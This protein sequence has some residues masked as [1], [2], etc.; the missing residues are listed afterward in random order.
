MNIYIYI[1]LIDIHKYDLKQSN[2]KAKNIK[3]VFNRLS[4][5]PSSFCLHSANKF[6]DSTRKVVLSRVDASVAPTPQVDAVDRQD[7]CKA[8]GQFAKL[9]RRF[10]TISGMPMAFTHSGS[11]SFKMF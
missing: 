8:G 5:H 7:R 2:V 10:C 11:C 6:K 9:S 4:L 3:Y 1:Y